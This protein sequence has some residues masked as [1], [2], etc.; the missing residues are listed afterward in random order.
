LFW[1]LIIALSFYVFSLFETRLKPTINTFAETR[2]RNIAVREINLAVSEQLAF[3]G[4]F[5]YND[6]VQID[7]STDGSIEAIRTNIQ[8]INMLQSELMLLI[9]ERIWNIEMQEVS[10]PI[11][12]LSGTQLLMGRGPGIPIR[13]LP[14]GDA[15]VE[16][17][18]SFTSAG[19]NQTRHQLWLEITT[20]I[21]IIIPTGNSRIQVAAQ[22]PL[23]ETIIVG[24]VPDTYMNLDGTSGLILG[25]QGAQFGN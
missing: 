8:R 18:H 14:A 13:L 9:N 24:R 6:F 3:G 10:I 15:E 17:L 20:K 16:I 22:V 23:A 19:I 7:K 2:A 11:G 5:D 21:E 25:T 12:N 4:S 1:I